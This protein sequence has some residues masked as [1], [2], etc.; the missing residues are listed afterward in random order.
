MS[1]AQAPS[2]YP[3]ITPDS[4]SPL[5]NNNDVLQAAVDIGSWQFLK[6][7]LVGQLILCLFGLAV[8]KLLFLRG[9]FDTRRLFQRQRNQKRNQ[10][11]VKD[12]I[13][14]AK[15]LTALVDHDL[16]KKLAYD[17]LRHPKETCDWLAVFIAQILTVV[18]S[19]AGLHAHILNHLDRVL[20]HD[21]DAKDTADTDPNDTI[22]K[23]RIPFLSRVL[24]QSIDLGSHH[25][26]ILG[27]KINF[28]ESGRSRLELDFDWQDHLSVSIDTQVLCNWPV[29][30]AAS[31]PVQLTVVLQRIRGTLAFEWCH[32]ETS[33]S[34]PVSDN[35]SASQNEKLC[36][37][38]QPTKPPSELNLLITLLHGTDVEFDVKSLIGHRSKIK[39]LPKL[40]E[41]ISN[42]L[43]YL[44]EEEIV[45]P[46]YK[47]IRVPL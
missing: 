24:L 22:P 32:R 40:T 6:G 19:S 25:P 13:E 35:D 27:A 20:N 34:V 23:S 5:Q 36:E 44:V 7:F 15:M 38:A 45:W 10:N 41:L 17:P 29:D 3:S 47:V 12:K 8:V 33:S 46:N 21:D 42:Y 43:R 14:T 37:S 4:T 18:R 31:L 28:A 11:E 16:L 1:T 39:D 2:L 9:P 26:R 30:I